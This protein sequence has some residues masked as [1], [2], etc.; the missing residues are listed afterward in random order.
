MGKNSVWI[1][2]TLGGLGLALGALSLTMEGLSLALG[3]LSLVLG[4]K[5]GYIGTFKPESAQNDLF[6]LNFALNYC[7][8]LKLSQIGLFRRKELLPI[9]QYLPCSKKQNYE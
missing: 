5:L 1:P 2:D 3:G 6:W 9:F 7:I 8:W 4:G